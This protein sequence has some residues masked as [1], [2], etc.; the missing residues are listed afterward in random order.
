MGWEDAQEVDFG[1]YQSVTELWWQFHLNNKKG[2]GRELKRL[3]DRAPW[4]T[5]YAFTEDFEL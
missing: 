4:D 3:L 5:D 2:K 1:K